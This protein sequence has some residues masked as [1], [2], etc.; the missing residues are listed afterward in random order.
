MSFKARA[1]AL[2]LFVLGFCTSMVALPVRRLPE[3][4]VSVFEPPVKKVVSVPNARLDNAILSRA[5]KQ[6]TK[7]SIT[8]NYGLKDASPGRF[9]G[10]EFALYIVMMI[11]VLAIV[12]CVGLLLYFVCSWTSV[13]I[14]VALCPFV[15]DELRRAWPSWDYMGPGNLYKRGVTGND[16]VFGSYIYL[17]VV[18]ALVV[19]VIGLVT[20][21]SSWEDLEEGGGKVRRVL[22]VA[23]FLLS[24]GLVAFATYRAFSKGV[25][26]FFRG[27][28]NVMNSD[29]CSGPQ[30]WNQLKP[31]QKFTELALYLGFLVG[32]IP[33]IGTIWDIA[34]IV[35]SI[36]VIQIESSTFARTNAAIAVAASIMQLVG[37]ILASFSERLE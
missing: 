1:F 29:M 15:L 17:Y 13:A 28:E 37:S 16:Y 22:A 12:G 25:P 31:I 14:G 18:Y 9:I 8:C 11:V 35:C 26:S 10:L 2:I 30:S 20:L 36:I 7:A 34:E 5:G 32:W 19:V 6:A 4:I 33:I 24:L 3:E 27:S 21:W 23:G